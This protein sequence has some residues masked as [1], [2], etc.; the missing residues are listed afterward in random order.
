MFVN[1]VF[2]FFHDEFLRI[3]DLLFPSFF[4]GLKCRYYRWAIRTVVMWCLWMFFAETFPA[5]RFVWVFFGMFVFFVFWT[6][7]GLASERVFNL[8]TSDNRMYSSANVDEAWWAESG[9]S[10]RKN[11]KQKSCFAFSVISETRAVVQT[12]NGRRRSLAGGKSRIAAKRYC[13]NSQCPCFE[14]ENRCSEK[15]CVVHSFSHLTRKQPTWTIINRQNHHKHLCKFYFNFNFQRSCF[16]KNVLKMFKRL[17]WFKKNIL[18]KRR[19]TWWSNEKQINKNR[20]R[21]RDFA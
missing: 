20:W 9:L 10:R 14:R 16:K 19:D 21:I 2:S 4:F 8:K 7:N 11:W 12:S 1:V 15:K 17:V 5:K 3:S 6:Q 18:K 13:K